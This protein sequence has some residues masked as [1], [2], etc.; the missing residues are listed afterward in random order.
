MTQQPERPDWSSR[1]ARLVEVRGLPA[2]PE[3][4]RLRMDAFFDV[5][6]GLLDFEEQVGGKDSYFRYVTE[7][8]KTV[9]DRKLPLLEG[10]FSSY[11]AAQRYFPQLIWAY[12]LI[13]DL[14][15]SEIQAPGE[16][17]SAEIVKRLTNLYLNDQARV[18]IDLN[19]YKPVVLA[20]MDCVPTRHTAKGISPQAALMQQRWEKMVKAWAHFEGRHPAVNDKTVRHVGE[21]GAQLLASPDAQKEDPFLV[22]NCLRHLMMQVDL[23]AAALH[24]PLTVLGTS[25]EEKSRKELNYQ[26]Q[27]AVDIAYGKI[28]GLLNAPNPPSHLIKGA[29]IEH[30]N[31]L[32][33]EID[34]FVSQTAY[35][36]R[37][38][39]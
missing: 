20:M 8:I 36:G 7:L 39:E 16:D 22:L 24:E 6:G 34:G 15:H 21:L 33:N 30:T 2:T 10:Q 38:R 28:L 18:I 19:L 37:K 23:R 5:G 9:R 27:D 29:T 31:R 12:E 13:N 32:L 3:E 14:Y 17:P 25:N 35:K 26:L 4:A 11:P 1:I